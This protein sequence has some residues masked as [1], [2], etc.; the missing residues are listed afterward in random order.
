MLEG[1]KHRGKRG[2]K[3][4]LDVVL[5]HL[6]LIWWIQYDEYCWIH[7]ITLSFLSNMMMVITCA[8]CSKILIGLPP[9]NYFQSHLLGILIQSVDIREKRILTVAVGEYQGGSLIWWTLYCVN[10]KICCWNKIE[11]FWW[12][13]A[14][15]IWSFQNVLLRRRPQRTEIFNLSRERF[16]SALKFI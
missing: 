11:R 10:L 13:V 7:E 12:S 6:I 1:L 2:A 5:S 8:E 3:E 14:R 4:I 9:V 16:S 15:H